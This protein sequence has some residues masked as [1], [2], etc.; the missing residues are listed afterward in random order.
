MRAQDTRSP[1]DVPKP[2]TERR[3][4]EDSYAG[5]EFVAYPLANEYFDLLFAHADR[6]KIANA[7]EIGSYPGPFLAALGECGFELNGVDFH[8]GNAVEL[9]NWLRSLGHDVDSF[10]SVDFHE[11]APGRTFDLV[12]SLGF[13]E[14][15]E[16]FREVI[17]RHAR[18]VSAGGYLF[19]TTPNFRG[20]AQ[21]WLHRALDSE[22]L[23]RH[24]L[25]AMDPGA[26]AEVLVPMGFDILFCGYFGH[27]AFW[28][29]VN[30]RR[31]AAKLWAARAAAR[32]FWN[33][34]KIYHGD[35]RHFSPHCGLVAQRRAPA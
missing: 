11:Y 30:D 34:R 18:L 26:W 14:H 10:Q 35:S 31:S 3:H 5:A 13:I 9:P 23:A 25:P 22:N 28:V 33:I 16:D 4:W 20:A 32:L 1:V 6:S 21:Q 19:I 7:L 29:D 24:H 2:L 15:F 17:A 12:Y 8:P 27:I